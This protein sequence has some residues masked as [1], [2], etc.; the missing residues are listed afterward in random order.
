LI[1]CPYLGIKFQLIV[2]Y[3]S[4]LGIKISKYIDDCPSLGLRSAIVL[5]KFIRYNLDDEMLEL[6]FPLLHWDLDIQV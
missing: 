2:D 6:F 4:F 3:L 1:F 5:K